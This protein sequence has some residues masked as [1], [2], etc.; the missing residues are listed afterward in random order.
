MS[1]LPLTFA[2]AALLTAA[3]PARADCDLLYA[4]PQIRARLLA[5]HHAN[6][7]RRAQER[8]AR[9]VVVTP[10]RRAPPQLGRSP[11][12]EPAR[13]GGKPASPG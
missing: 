9:D 13:G 3:G 2:L 11:A 6:E 8:K 10:Q 5:F 1:R 12:S 7:L 4:P